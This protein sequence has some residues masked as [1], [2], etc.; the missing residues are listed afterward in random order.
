MALT[1][2]KALVISLVLTC[3][4]A[5]GAV[6]AGIFGGETSTAA[7]FSTARLVPEDAAVFVAMDSDFESEQWKALNELG[8]TFD[9]SD[10]I[11]LIKSSV[12]EDSELDWERDV[13]PLLGGQIG[14]FLRE[15]PAAEDSDAQ[16][17]FAVLIQTDDGSK[18]LASLKASLERE[19]AT[20]GRAPIEPVDY[21]G[22]R[23]EG[24]AQEGG[25]PLLIALVADHLVLASE[26][27]ALHA[28]IDVE[29]GAPSLGD[30]APFTRTTRRV[31]ANS[32]AL[33]YL[34]MNALLPLG[35]SGLGLLPDGGGS[36]PDVAESSLAALLSGELLKDAA[37]VMT[38]AVSP[39]S[40]RLDVVMTLPEGTPF[41]EE[42]TTKSF[43][44]RFAEMA[45]A[46][47][48]AFLAGYD[49]L[50]SLDP[51]LDSVAP[52]FSEL[53]AMFGAD[54]QKDLLDQMQGEFA[55]ALLP[56]TK[57]QPEFAVMIEVADQAKAQGVVVG[58]LAFAAIGGMETRKETAAGTDYTVVPVDPQVDIAIAFR[59]GVLLAT[60]GADR[61]R[62]I[63]EG[64]ASGG[65]AESE[66][67][68]AVTAGLPASYTFIGYAD[69]QALVKAFGDQ[70]DQGSDGENV[71]AMLEGL[72]ALVAVG[73]QETDAVAFSVIL[74]TK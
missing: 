55:F 11:G 27:S 34:D 1:N 70:I 68:K 16:P 43:S 8:K 57:D 24:Y 9:Q 54:I 63:L 3:I 6:Y 51:L 36:S 10:L 37:T 7:G 60:M 17:K 30:S 71:A 20:S 29:Q 12:T 41:P 73:R 53:N 15:L 5:G 42:L 28:V 56:G 40:A 25:E 39:D 74:Q 50:K 45:P 4:L 46:D 31:N 52:D 47:S 64:G 65:L 33:V 18:A 22:I 23:I 44:S 2:T 13:A 69:I 32:L 38:L 72:D 58:L 48:I 49:L 61:M 21:R 66:R 19:A 59:D 62:S 35:E 14:L 67:Y 26:E